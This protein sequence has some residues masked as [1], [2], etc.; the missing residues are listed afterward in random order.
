[1]SDAPQYHAPTHLGD[2][3]QRNRMLLG[4][5]PGAFIGALLAFGMQQRGTLPHGVLPILAMVVAAFVVALF[6]VRAITQSAGRLAGEVVMP[7][8]EGTYSYQHSHIQALEAQG[9]MHDAAAS[10]D[11]VASERDDPHALLRAADLH[12]R[13]LQDPE[14]AAERF[15]AARDRAGRFPDA[16]RYAQQRL[17][18]LYLGVLDD[19][20][21][22]LVELRRLIHDHPQ[23]RE[24]AGARA[25]IARLKRQRFG[26]DAD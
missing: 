11:R 10:W 22:A 5:L 20:G 8:A 4:A 17:I 21:R 26:E 2:R 14:G 25:A 13:E 23:S 1:M 19:E 16:A 9:R 24:A 3:V 6:I 12:A 7:S 18:D 15:R